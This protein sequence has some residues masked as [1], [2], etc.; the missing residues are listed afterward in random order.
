MKRATAKRMALTI[1][2][3]LKSAAGV[4]G[5]PGS[6]HEALRVKRAW[7]FGSTAKG[8]EHPNDLDIIMEM[9]ECGRRF[10]QKGAVQKR[11]R[12]GGARLDR[13]FFRTH[14]VRMP[15][16]CQQD[17]LRWIRGTMKMVRLHDYG[18]DGH[19]ADGKIMI[20]PRN[21]LRATIEARPTLPNTARRTT[22]SLPIGQENVAVAIARETEETNLSP[23]QRP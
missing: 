3:R 5:T 17:A 15:V 2:E 20:Y 8:S 23:L 1:A 19:L 21:E 4:I 22:D 12:P 14:R 16:S 18:I 7:V 13:A 6:D 9:H 10:W 11:T